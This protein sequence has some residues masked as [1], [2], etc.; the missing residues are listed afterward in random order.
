[1]EYSGDDES[2]LSPV[3]ECHPNGDLTKLKLAKKICSHYDPE[4]V[5]EKF[6]EQ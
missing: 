6:D 1:V 4:D 2:A 3:L 5:K